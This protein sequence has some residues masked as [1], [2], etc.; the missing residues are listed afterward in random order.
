MISFAVGPLSGD[1][2]CPSNP[3]MAFTID[4][5]Q[6]LGDRAVIDSRDLRSRLRR[7]DS[8]GVTSLL[9]DDD[10][11]LGR[12]RRH[13][14]TEIGIDRTPPLQQPIALFS[15]SFPCAYWARLPTRQS[16]LCVGVLLEVEPPC[17]VAL[18]PPI[19]CQG[20]EVVLI[21]EI[22]KND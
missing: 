13:V 21:L 9:Q 15:G 2:A 1:Q 10:W 3:E 12:T 11:S 5:E 18:A 8:P 22:P 14:R 19:H 7:I 20:D 16:D 6:S 4:L 17:R